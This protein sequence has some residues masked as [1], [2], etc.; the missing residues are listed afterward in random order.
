MKHTSLLLLMLAGLN[1]AALAWQTTTSTVPVEERHFS[2]TWWIIGVIVVL[3]LGM[4]VY[5]N[6]K[7]NP[8][9]DAR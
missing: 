4:L 6:I 3:A 2:W 1:T 5:V 7:K 8:R 9:K